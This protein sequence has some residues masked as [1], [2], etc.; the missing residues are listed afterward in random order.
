[1]RAATGWSSPG[2]LDARVR[3]DRGRRAGGA[4]GSLVVLP[5]DTVYGIGTQA[6]RSRS[7]RPAVR[8]QGP[9]ARARAPGPRALQGGR[10][11][12]RELRRTR[13]GARA[14]LLGRPA[15]DRAAARRA[16]PGV[17]P[18]R[19]PADDRRPDA[20]RP[21]RARGAGAHGAARGE[22]REPQ[23]RAHAL[24]LRRGR[25]G[26]RRTRSRCTSVRRNRWSAPPPPSSTS[27]TASRSWYAPAR[28]RN[29]RSPRPCDESCRL[30]AGRGA[31]VDSR[32]HGK[33][34][35]GVHGQRVP[36]A[37]RRGVPASRTSWTRMGPARR[38]SRPR[39]RWGGP[40][41]APTRIRS[42]RPPSTGSTSRAI[43]RGSSIAR[44][45]AASSSDPGDGERARR[46]RSYRS[47]ARSVARFTLKEFVRLLEALPRPRRRA[48]PTRSRPGRGRRAA[49]RRVRRQ[50]ARRGHRG[51]ARH[52]PR[53][54]SARWRAS[55]RRGARDSPTALVGRPHARDADPA[56]VLVVRICDGMRPR[57]V[58]AQGSPEGISDRA[59][60]RG[61]R[62]RDRFGGD[63]GLPRLLRGRRARGRRRPRRPRDRARWVGA[64][65]AARRQQGDRR[66]GGALQRPA[67]RGALPPAQRRERAR[68]GRPDRRRPARPGDPASCGSTRRSRAGGTSDGCNRSPRSN[69][70][71]ADVRP[72]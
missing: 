28:C 62:R 39:G 15:H 9:P 71:N 34:P 26:V 7:D 36:V 55:S 32:P 42:R 13:R 17:G 46:R 4:R 43:A 63:G 68:D 16:R 60:A 27:R 20:A 18:R 67:P 19:R 8:G 44:D 11:A 45:G 31:G 59:G 69:E 2:R 48:L 58:S 66:S 1:M 40:V 29:E 21:A 3:P 65:R 25:G 64:G 56:S 23:R 22:Q 49:T 10:P 5:T 72:H 38:R 70:E 51:P 52:A 54:V 12:D 24:D 33:G 50:P 37:A 41:Q 57:G 35:G 6:R 61:A 14:P 30:G 47:E 53:R